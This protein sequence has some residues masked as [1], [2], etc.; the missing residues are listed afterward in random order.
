[1]I[2][3]RP[4]G[5]RQRDPFLAYV[6]WY[7]SHELIGGTFVPGARSVPRR[8]ARPELSHRGSAV[9]EHGTPHLPVSPPCRRVAET[10][11]PGGPLRGLKHISA[12]QTSAASARVCPRLRLGSPAVRRQVCTGDLLRPHHVPAVQL[13]AFRVGPRAC[14]TAGRP[15]GRHNR[16]PAPS[17]GASLPRRPDYRRAV[18]RIKDACGAARG[19]RAIGPVLTR[20]PARSREANHTIYCSA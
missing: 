6:W 8:S 20:P 9:P 19:G 4:V 11:I 10:P 2:Y 16:I 3:C 5:L 15:W 12:Q 18:T 17:R 13:R 14:P 1:L 7:K